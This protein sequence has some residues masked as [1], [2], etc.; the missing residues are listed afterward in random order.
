MPPPAFFQ[1]GVHR[2]SYHQ[3]WDWTSDRQYIVHLYITRESQAGWTCRHFVS[4]YRALLREELTAI[5]HEAGFVEVRWLMP[6]DSGFYQPLVLARHARAP[7]AA[8]SDW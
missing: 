4:V 3:V 5:L 7:Q 6:A 8:S 2:R 1:D